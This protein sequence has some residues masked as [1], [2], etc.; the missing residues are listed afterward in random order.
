MKTITITRRSRK[1]GFGWTNQP[2]Q[3]PAGLVIRDPVESESGL[4]PREIA[5]AHQKAARLNNGNDWAWMI[6]FDGQPIADR[7]TRAEILILGRDVG[8]VDAVQVSL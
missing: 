1:L 6:F 8:L 7:N 5:E 4:T 3:A 2:V